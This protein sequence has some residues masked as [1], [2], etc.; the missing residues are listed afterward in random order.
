MQPLTIT[1]YNIHKGMSPLNR[2]LQLEAMGKALAG[3]TPDILC[4]QEVQGRNL[5]RLVAYNEYPEQS[6]HEWFG[7]YLAL[8]SNYGKNAEYSYGHHGNA[9]LSR[10]PLDPKH[11]VNI[12]V[13]HLE[14][15]GVLHC[16]IY[17]K[18]WDSKVVVLNLSLIH[19]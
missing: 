5:R 11:N 1:S 7:E 8:K 16:E 6:Q 10:Y 19:I 18:D 15:R 4:L 3:V 2:L 12:T 13:N 17:P 14:K 9:V